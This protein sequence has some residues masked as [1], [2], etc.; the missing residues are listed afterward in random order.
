VL[1]PILRTVV[2]EDGVWAIVFA[3]ASIYRRLEEAF[4]ALK[5]LLSRE[6]E[7]GTLID[8][9]FWVYKQRGNKD[10]NI[11]ALVVLYTFDHETV[12]LFSILVRLPTL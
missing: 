1:L 8:D 3:N 6:P 4:D 7:R 11:P 10:L 9:Y 2:E 12:T 5:W